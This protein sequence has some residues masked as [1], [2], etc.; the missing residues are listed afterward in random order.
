MTHDACLL[1][2]QDLARI[3][4]IGSLSWGTSDIALGDSIL[5]CGIISVVLD[6]LDIMWCKRVSMHKL[7]LILLIG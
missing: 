4:R 5:D 2:Q 3:L 1:L 6:L 7:L